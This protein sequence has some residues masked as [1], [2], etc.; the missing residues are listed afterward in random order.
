MRNGRSRDWLTLISTLF[1]GLM[2]VVALF[3]PYL[4]PY[5]DEGMG[6]PNIAQKLLPPSNNHPLGTDGLGRDMG[7]RIL[8]GARVALVSATAVV[9]TAVVIG[10]FLG[11]IAGY[12]RGWLDELIMRV[13]DMFLAFPPLLLAIVIAVALEPGLLSTII[14][15]SLTWWPWYARLVRAETLLVREQTYILAAQ[16]LGMSHGRILWRHVLP[17][18]QTAV[19]IQATADMGAA[20]LTVAG[21][22]F[23][24]LG[25]QPPTADWG[26]MVNE[27][28]LYVQSGRWWLITF[29][30]LALFLT[31][32]SFNL[33]GDV[34]QVRRKS[35]IENH[36]ESTES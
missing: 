19:V 1:I 4:T 11:V 17:N 31:A 32:L 15:I 2:I 8:F 28:R 12:F 29:P 14:A 22:S 10:G 33:V 24:G 7:A 27:G 30:G 18:V 13:T 6:T 20:M 26:V 9:G 34:A 36:L 21:L 35:T 3:A 5:R 16:A 25:V 23:L